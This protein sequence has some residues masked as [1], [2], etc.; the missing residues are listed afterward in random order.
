MIQAGI[1][2]TSK[3]RPNTMV[4]EDITGIGSDRV[5][6][7]RSGYQQP[8][9]DSLRDVANALAPRTGDDP[10]HLQW[11]LEI[12]AGRRSRVEQREPSSASRAGPDLDLIIRRIKLRLDQK[13]PTPERQELELKLVRAR[14]ARD[15][16]RLADEL[17]AEIETE[18]DR[19]TG[20]GS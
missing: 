16:K 10:A 13:P 8:T 14:R 20:E 15:A 1:P 11:E 9:I 4:F 7:W 3:G 18:L 19:T 6:R 5:S 17:I 12:A 2:L